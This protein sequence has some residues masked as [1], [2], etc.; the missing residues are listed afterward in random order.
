MADKDKSELFEA[1]KK[2]EAEYLDKYNSPNW[3]LVGNYVRVDALL[4]IM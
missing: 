3:K 1:A 4:E 2:S